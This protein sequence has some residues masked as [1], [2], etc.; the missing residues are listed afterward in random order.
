MRAVL[1]DTVLA[2]APAEDLVRIEG[3]WYFPP[4]SLTPGLFIESPTAYT[5]GW[6]GDAQY[7][8][9]LIAG[10]P[11]TDLAWSYP[12]PYPASLERVGRDFAGYIAFDPAVSVLD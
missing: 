4:A 6:K 2:E 7:Y 1:R 12:R 10:E 8:S 3:N 11:Q 9:V 5:C